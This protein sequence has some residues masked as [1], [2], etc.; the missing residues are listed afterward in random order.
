MG[1]PLRFGPLGEIPAGLL[2]NLY[3]ATGRLTISA[4]EG[5]DL[6]IYR[7][8]LQVDDVETSLDV[9]AKV[10]VSATPQVRSGQ[11]LTIRATAGRETSVDLSD[12]IGPPE[13]IGN[14]QPI[15]FHLY[16][17]TPEERASVR[18]LQARIESAR[19]L[20]VEPSS[21]LKGEFS[22]RLGARF[23]NGESELDFTLR[24][25]VGN[26]T[27]AVAPDDEVDIPDAGLRAEVARALNKKGGEPIIR[28]EMESLRILGASERNIRNL[29]GLECASGLRVLHLDRNQ[30]TNVSPLSGLTALEHLNLYRNQITNVS[31]LSGLT[32][33]EYLNLGQNQITNMSPLSGLTALED[34]FLDGH[35]ITNVSPLSGLT[36]LKVLTL[37][38]NQIT[39]VSPLS[40]LT[41]LR[42]LH[43]DRNQITNVSPLSGLT[44][45]EW[46]S[47]TGNQITDIGPLVSNTGLG[48]G[49]LVELWD[50]PLSARSCSTQVRALERR[51]VVVS[52]SCFE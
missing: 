39:N 37:L 49:D 1:S 25:I 6:G 12:V 26:N 42:I 27:C 52:D 50:N 9:V 31:P 48:N 3:R 18:R 41:A 15:R 20:K 11:S 2:V 46:L 30:I 21:D 7:F 14:H 36:A 23:P 43:L 22:L 13:H 38:D 10:N 29:T 34:L 47:L 44:A 5:T 17:D 33:L 35:Q 40:G 4:A 19:L 51:G 28:D 16:I 24:V 8:G 32:A 45:L